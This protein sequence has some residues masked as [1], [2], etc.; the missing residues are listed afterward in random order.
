[1]P[2]A[3]PSD[4]QRSATTRGAR[5]RRSRIERFVAMK[6]TTFQLLADSKFDLFRGAVT[7]SVLRNFAATC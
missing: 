1:M 6:V 2:G 3:P 5:N 7:P 4:A